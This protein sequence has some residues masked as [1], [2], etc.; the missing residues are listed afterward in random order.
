MSVDSC[1]LHLFRIFVLM[2]CVEK[3]DA[4][5]SVLIMQ[6]YLC[7]F[8]HAIHDVILQTALI[9]DIM[10]G[11]QLFIFLHASSSE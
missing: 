10:R 8:K 7:T 4:Q 2:A 6:L 9:S 11:N 3:Y 1:L 5:K